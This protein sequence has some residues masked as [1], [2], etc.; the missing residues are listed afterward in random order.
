MLNYKPFANI[1][2]TIDFSHLVSVFPQESSKN[3]KKM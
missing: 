2:K 3:D 1:C